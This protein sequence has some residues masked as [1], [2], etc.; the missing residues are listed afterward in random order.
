MKK[1]FLV[2]FALLL[3]GSRSF[4]QIYTTGNGDGYIQQCIYW[5][6][7]VLLPVHITSFESKCSENKVQLSWKVVSDYNKGFFTIEKSYDGTVFYPIQIIPVKEAGVEINYYSF[8][9]ES[10]NGAPS[11]YRIKQTNT[12]GNSEYSSILTTRC[13]SSGSEIKFYPNPTTGLLNICFNH[14]EKP[15]KQVTILIRNMTGQTVMQCKAGITNKTISLHGLPSG[16]Y[17]IQIRTGETT[18]FQKIFLQAQ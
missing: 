5:A 15:E 10:Q 18:S 1:K 12:E 16:C 2:F 3:M 6:P 4:S 9:D 8:T 13:N 17:T 7:L 11:F 14:A